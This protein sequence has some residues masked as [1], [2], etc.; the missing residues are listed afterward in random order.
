MQHEQQF[1]DHTNVYTCVHS[2]AVI[3][4]VETQMSSTVTRSSQLVE[5]LAR[6]EVLHVHKFQPK[7]NPR[8]RDLII[9]HAKISYRCR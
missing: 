1:H 9:N 7:P 5:L 6:D 3:M 2:Y 4:N 8:E